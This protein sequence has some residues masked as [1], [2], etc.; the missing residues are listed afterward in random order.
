ML[1]LTHKDKTLKKL[2][3]ILNLQLALKSVNCITDTFIVYQ[4]TK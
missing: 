3:I 2:N 4:L 1:I